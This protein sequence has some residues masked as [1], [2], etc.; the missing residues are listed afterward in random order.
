[1]DGLEEVTRAVNPPEVETG[2]TMHVE[3]PPW[4]ESYEISA[5]EVDGK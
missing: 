1:M 3:V 4:A 2:S 5:T